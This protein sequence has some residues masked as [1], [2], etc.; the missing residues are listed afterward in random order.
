MKKCPFCGSPRRPEGI[1]AQFKKAPR[2]QQIFLS[3]ILLGGFLAW[4][5]EDTPAPTE[6]FNPGQSN[7]RVLTYDPASQTYTTVPK[8]TKSMNQRRAIQTK[9]PLV[10]GH[11]VKLRWPSWFT[12]SLKSWDEALYPALQQKDEAMIDKMFEYG[13]VQELSEGTWIEIQE[14]GPTYYKAKI[15]QT[16]NRERE[17][18]EVYVP[19]DIL[20]ER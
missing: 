20:F 5:T 13:V 7:G 11:R 1:I 15:R 12:L 14:V 10:I 8:L 19:R 6:T 9:T 17:G 3:V 4:L 2:W 18:W 16:P